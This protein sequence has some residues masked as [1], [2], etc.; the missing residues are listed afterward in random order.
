[1]LFILYW[2]Y[3][4]EPGGAKYVLI[5][6]LSLGI[7]ISLF[8]LVCI[9]YCKSVRSVIINNIERPDDVIISYIM[10]YIIPLLSNNI[11]V[12]ASMIVNFIL[13]ITIGY[14]YIRLNLIYLNPL[15]ALFGYISY[16]GDKD[17]IVITN[18]NFNE[19]KRISKRGLN[20]TYLLNGILLARK[21]DN[22][23]CD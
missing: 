21:E 19:L 16:R 17:I 22:I 6:V 12:K 11:N 2:D 8:T 4:Q 5:V 10:T 13:F 3:F 1:M 18:M 20:G 23:Q 15:W 7:I 9:K 14:L